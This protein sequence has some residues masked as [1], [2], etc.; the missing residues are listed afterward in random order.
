MKLAIV[1]ASKSGN[2]E[3]L[4]DLLLRLFLEQE[5]SVS[6]YP[7][8]EFPFE[9]LT[10]FD[11]VMVGTYTWGSGEIPLEMMALFQAFEKQD[12]KDVL[13]GVFGTGDS[14]YPHF[15]GAVDLF[16][17]MLYQKSRLAVTLKVELRPQ[18]Q[19][20]EKCQKFV[21]IILATMV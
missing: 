5:A 14:H 18:I 21:R 2:T 13:T 10:S 4:A 8:E 19:D 20:L 3:E 11:A 1:Y 6:F 15:C 17:D 12:A 9:R 7:V 16:R